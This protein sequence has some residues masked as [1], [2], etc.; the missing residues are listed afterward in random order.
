VELVLIRL[1]SVTNSQIAE[2]VLEA[3]DS[4]PEVLVKG[5]PVDRRVANAQGPEPGIRGATGRGRPEVGEETAIV[6]NASNIE[7]AS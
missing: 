1:I 3:A 5:T 6:E 2:L 7:V 4:K